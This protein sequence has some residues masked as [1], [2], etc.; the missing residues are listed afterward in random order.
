MAP[1]SLIDE[2]LEE[3]RQLELGAVSGSKRM[4]ATVAGFR[5]S[6]QDPAEIKEQLTEHELLI[7]WVRTH[8]IIA[9]VPLSAFA[10]SALRIGQL[11]G[12]ASMH[13]IEG[14][15]QAGATLYAD[16]RGLSDV[17]REYGQESCTSTRGLLVAA[18]AAG[19]LT[20]QQLRASIVH[21]VR[22]AHYF[23][24]LNPELL[25]GLASDS[26][27]KITPEARPVFSRL[28]DPSIPLNQKVRIA[29]STLR[30]IAAVGGL[31]G[32]VLKEMTQRFLVDFSEHHYFEIVA[33]SLRATVKQQFYFL[34]L[35]ADE[36]DRTI[37]EFLQTKRA[38]KSIG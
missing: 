38:A 29:G 17:A 20:D 28:A 1:R 32:T 6:E 31:G 34:P 35:Q 19:H 5:F 9:T 24:P 12:T 4:A 8:T 37:E 10:Q 18:R 33:H 36:V 21:L 25:V 11:I 22:L 2:L 13:A 30:H 7:D 26:G 15:R 27:H 14:T 23:V 16:D 3:R